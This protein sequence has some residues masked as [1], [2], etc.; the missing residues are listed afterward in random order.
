MVQKCFKVGP[1]LRFS[2][3]LKKKSFPT[4]TWKFLS[5]HTVHMDN[6]ERGIWALLDDTEE[7]QANRKALTL[8]VPSCRARGSLTAGPWPLTSDFWLSS[9]ASIVK[10]LKEGEAGLT[11]TFTISGTY[12]CSNLQPYSSRCL[13]N[14]IFFDQFVF[15]VLKCKGLRSSLVI[16]SFKDMLQN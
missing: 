6:S 8:Q 12:R 3:K 13:T 16:L 5:L 14:V 7:I 4:D 11:V 2:L 1:V 15:K 10:H 9:S